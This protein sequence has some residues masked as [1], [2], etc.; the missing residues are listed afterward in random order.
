M[1]R[2]FGKYRGKVA[3]NID[4]LQL[5]RLQVQ[6]P[7]I[8][9]S[10]RLSWAMPCTPYA[11]SG[12]GLFLLPPIGAN[13]W[14]EFELGDPDYPIWA[15]CFWGQTQNPAAP[16]ALPPLKMLKTASITLKMDDTPGAGG[17]TLEVKPPAVVVPLKVVM[18]STGIEINVNNISVLKLKL[19]EAELSVG[20]TSKITLTPSTV[21]VAEGATNAQLTLTGI[22]LNSPPAQLKL[23]TAS[24]I[25]LGVVPT[26][27]KVS[28]A[29][30]E[31]TAASAKIQ[32][33]PALIELANV[34]ANV[35]LSPVTVNVNN[36]AL[37]VI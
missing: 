18:N 10:D 23:S 32:M 3:N 36:G 22:E 21:E 31:A 1:R 35:K 24:G 15:G 17:V 28:T 7:S 33:S 26:T 9:G 6:V 25:E 30:F 13:I 16:T 27:V 29:G 19:A 11:G 14:V 12:E 37:E 20:E 34:A 2:F 8:Y 4:P 5:G